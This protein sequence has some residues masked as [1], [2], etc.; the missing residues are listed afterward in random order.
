MAG[1]FRGDLRAGPDRMVGLAVTVLGWAGWR[2]C[3]M[4]GNWVGPVVVLWWG[5]RWRPRRASLG[6]LG[7]RGP[8]GGG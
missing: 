6:L 3:G 1:V 2:V 7:C 8:S 4:G 5:R